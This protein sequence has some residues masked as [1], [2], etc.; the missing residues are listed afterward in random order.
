MS[1][2]KMEKGDNDD[3]KFFIYTLVKDWI[4]RLRVNKMDVG[5]TVQ[6]NYI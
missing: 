3:Y 6:N 4:A 5:V 1:R 2:N